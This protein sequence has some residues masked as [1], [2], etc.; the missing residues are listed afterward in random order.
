MVYRLDL[1][2][3]YEIDYKFFNYLE[4]DVIYVP[5]I[6]QS[7][8]TNDFMAI[9]N[10]N[11]IEKYSNLITQYESILNQCY[12]RCSNELILKVYLDSIHMKIKYFPFSCLLR[13]GLRLNGCTQYIPISEEQTNSLIIKE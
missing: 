9:G 5:N 8:G 4:D 13:G 3:L 12:V 7:K 11:A 10:F 2:T 1:L 6:D